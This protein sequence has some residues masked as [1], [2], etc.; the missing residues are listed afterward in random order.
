MTSASPAAVR[1]RRAA[2]EARVR[3]AVAVSTAAASPTATPVGSRP[4]DSGSVPAACVPAGRSVSGVA[5]G[6][7]RRAPAASPV[8]TPT[9]SA[10]AASP[11]TPAFTVV[12]WARRA[13][14][15]SETS[16]ARAPASAIS[17]VRPASPVA[18]RAIPAAPATS[19]TT[20][21]RA[22]PWMVSRAPEGA[23]SRTAP[24]AINRTRAPR[25]SAC[26]APVGAAGE[27]SP[28]A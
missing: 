16:H 22:A 23:A 4:A 10:G 14:L 19:A 24:C 8:P 28:A 1:V 25:A 12:R 5:R 6:T 3:Q 15:R 20:P 27:I 9:R 11:R 21:R 7:P 17:P 2:P 18:S 26:R 13:V